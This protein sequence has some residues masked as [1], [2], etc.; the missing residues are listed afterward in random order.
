MNLVVTKHPRPIG[1][2]S[3]VPGEKFMD[4]A[5]KAAAKLGVSECFFDHISRIDPLPGRLPVPFPTCQPPPPP[6]Q[7]NQLFLPV[8]SNQSAIPASP[9]QSVI[10]DHPPPPT[11][12]EASHW[13]N[14][15]GSLRPAFMGNY[16]IGS[17]MPE[18]LGLRW[19][20]HAV[21]KLCPTTWDGSG[22][23]DGP[24]TVTKV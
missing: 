3:K 10:A 5:T 21:S 20:Y 12:K 2:C 13:Y 16:A 9:K 1:K 8:Q 11:S 6:A 17:S 23:W 22:K 15:K 18:K 7:V 4:I 19:G 24:N 14:G